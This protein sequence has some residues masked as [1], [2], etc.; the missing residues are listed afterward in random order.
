MQDLTHKV[1]VITGGAEG[2]GRAF[3]EK[4]ASLKMR[5]LLADINAEK[6]E[7]AARE[8]RERYAVEVVTQVTDVSQEAAVNALADRAYREYQQVHLLFNNAGV[9]LGKTAWDTTKEEWDWVLGVN[10]FGVINGVRAFVPRMLAGEEE[11]H[12]INT[13]SA[14]GLLSQPS[15]AAYN[16]SKHGVVT[17]SE[18]LYHDLR[19]RKSKI[20]VSVLCPAWVK[21]RIADIQRYDDDKHHVDVAGMDPLT[22]KAS[23]AVAQAVAAGIS[24]ESVAE[25]TFEAIL[26]DKFYIMTHEPIRQAVQ[27][28]MTDIVEGRQPHLLPFS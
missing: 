6:L 20:S 3:A 25:K 5:L 14:A 4:A 26:N 21:T 11:G 12:I 28:R 9:A 15:F 10:L 22:L 1:A 18:G 8:L 23:Q 13:A 17:L 7:Q 27:I 24:S 16:V 2:I 19:L